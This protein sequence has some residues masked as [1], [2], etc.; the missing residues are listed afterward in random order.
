MPQ[1]DKF[2]YFTQFF[3]SCLIL[4]TF[5]IPI[6][7]DG[8]GVLGISRILKLRNQLLS[9]RGN[10]IGSNDPKTLEDISRKGFRKVR[11]FIFSFGMLIFVIGFFYSICLIFFS[12][13]FFLYLFSKIG[14]SLGGRA[15]SL[16]LMKMGCGGGLTFAIVFAV[17]HLLTPEAA[18]SLWNMVLHAGTD[19]GASSSFPKHE[20]E[21][22]LSLP[23]NLAAPQPLRSHVE[24]ELRVLF[25]IGKKHTISDS[26]FRNYLEPL[27]LDKA[28]VGFCRAL[29]ERVNSLQVEHYNKGDHIPFQFKTEKDRER[30]YSIVWEYADKLK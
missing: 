12:P 3:W 21:T 2:T 9:H 11:P 15:L 8:D 4:F 7:N 25:H 26:A 1:L 10:K 17:K 27:A 22:A 23:D 20:W 18:P 24:Q 30:L 5:Y 28:S 14:F 29:L 13:S 19:S 16:F 6:C